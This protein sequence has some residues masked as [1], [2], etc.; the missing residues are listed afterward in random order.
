MAKGLLAISLTWAPAIFHIFVALFPPAPLSLPL[1]SLPHPQK[2]LFVSK[3]HYFSYHRF[4]LATADP[5]SLTYGFTFASR[6]YQGIFDLLN[7]SN[8]I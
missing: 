6:D 1:P 3:A 4:A 8:Y 2:S 7:I 5:H